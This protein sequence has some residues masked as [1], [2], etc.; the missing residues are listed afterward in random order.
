MLE[1]RVVWQSS[2][3]LEDLGVNFLKAV[4][5]DT[6]ANGRKKPECPLFCFFASRVD[7]PLTVD[8]KAVYPFHTQR[9]RSPVQ[10]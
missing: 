9:T 10:A 7:Y 1:W 8:D 6:V 3:L 4:H 2:R 5:V